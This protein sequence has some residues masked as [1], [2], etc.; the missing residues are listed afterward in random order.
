MIFMKTVGF[1]PNHLCQKHL[2]SQEND[3]LKTKQ[4]QKKRK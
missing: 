1:G 2:L 3:D 4:K